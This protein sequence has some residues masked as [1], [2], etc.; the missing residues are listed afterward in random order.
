V[1]QPLSPPAVRALVKLGDG[2]FDGDS[3]EVIGELLGAGYARGDT[4]I[5][6]PTDCLHRGAPDRNNSNLGRKRPK[7]T[8]SWIRGR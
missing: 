1:T 6:K 7:E 8:G 5:H 3:P 2:P 4:L